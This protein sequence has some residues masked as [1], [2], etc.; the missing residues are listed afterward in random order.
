MKAGSVQAE[1]CC[2]YVK[3][4]KI[5]LGIISQLFDCWTNPVAH[6]LPLKC[7]M[8][9]LFNVTLRLLTNHCPFRR[10]GTETIRSEEGSNGRHQPQCDPL[11]R[12]LFQIFPPQKLFA[13][14]LKNCGRV[15]SRQSRYGH[16]L[17]QYKHFI[18][19]RQ[20]KF[21]C[22]WSLFSFKNLGLIF[23]STLLKY[24]IYLFAQ[25]DWF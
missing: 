17:Q 5:V 4:E 23:T 21:F 16:C 24:I 6:L 12:I 8:D 1:S 25:F 2:I 11:S 14:I 13:P 7:S 18:R 19:L 20:F 15:L 10:S 9:W 22:W 3:P